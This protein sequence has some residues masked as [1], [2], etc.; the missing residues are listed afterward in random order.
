MRASLVLIML[1]VLLAA[2]TLI[3]QSIGNNPI[4]SHGAVILNGGIEQ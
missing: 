2:F 4:E 1:Y 3:K